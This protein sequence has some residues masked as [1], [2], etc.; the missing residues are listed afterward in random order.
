M[1][2]YVHRDGDWVLRPPGR[3]DD[4]TMHLFVLRASTPQLQALCD[5]FINAPSGNAVTAAPL[6][7]QFPFVL[8]TVADIARGYSQD[9]EDDDWGWMPERDVGVFVPV[10]LQ[11]GGQQRV[12]NLLPYLYVDNFVAVLI[13]REVFG[14]PKM[15]ADIAIGASPFSCTVQSTVQ[16]AP[17]PWQAAGSGT[18]ATVQQVLP[19]PGLPLPGLLADAVTAIATALFTVAGLPGPPPPAF[20]AVPMAFL[21]QFRSASNRTDACHQSIVLAE[22]AVDSFTG[23][24]LW[25]PVF[26]ASP[27]ALTFPPAHSVKIAA[28]LGLGAGPVH[29]PLLAARLQVS[30]SLPH[31]TVLWSAP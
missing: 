15:L 18:V 11:S 12:A 13:G 2:A 28:T 9:V 29:H 21:K 19:L 16:A 8:V 3:L 31:G 25:L 1:A 24:R 7:A 22:A 30:F 26:G 14:F 5:R 10:A 6:F 17:N 27:F 23:G 4:V 20:T